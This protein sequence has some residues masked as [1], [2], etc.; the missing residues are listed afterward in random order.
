[1]T[2]AHPAETQPAS[3]K[4]TNWIASLAQ[5]VELSEADACALV[6][7]TTFGELTGGRKGTASKLIEQLLEMS[8]D[9]PR[10]ASEKQ[11]KWIKTL[12]SRAELS[13]SDA[14]AL[15]DAKAYTDLQGG[16]GGTASKL[17]TIL[18][19]RTGGNKKKGKSNKS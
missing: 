19:K 17:I 12:V 6:G 14:C 9:I 8:K 10:E 15:V 3:E 13:E 4:Q 2:K 5:G 18:K 11:I 7:V 1:M 16:S